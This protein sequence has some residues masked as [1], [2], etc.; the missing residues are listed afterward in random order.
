M[1]KMDIFDALFLLFLLLVLL[2][3]WY[4]YNRDS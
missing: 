3:M 4:L 1:I 2:G